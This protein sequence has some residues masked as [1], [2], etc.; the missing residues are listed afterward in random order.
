MATVRCSFL[1]ISR[2]KRNI[3]IREPG[4]TVEAKVKQNA[5]RMI[6][7]F[8][9]VHEDDMAGGPLFERQNKPWVAHPLQVHRKGWAYPGW[10]LELYFLG[11]DSGGTRPAR[12]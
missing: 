9:A 5:R 8:I 6:E 12:R 2:L 1:V 11:R 4:W 7:K 10:S 3:F